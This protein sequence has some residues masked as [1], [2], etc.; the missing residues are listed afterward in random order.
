MGK[1]LS[2]SRIRTALRPF[3]LF[4]QKH[5]REKNLLVGIQ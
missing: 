4:S 1:P 2:T 5:S 3:E